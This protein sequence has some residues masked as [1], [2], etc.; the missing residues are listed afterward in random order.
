MIR[1]ASGKYRRS[2]FNILTHKEGDIPGALWEEFWL[3]AERSGQRGAL[4]LFLEPTA[5]VGSRNRGVKQV[6]IDPSLQWQLV[7]QVAIKKSPSCLRQQPKLK[8][9]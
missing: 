6:T 8:A 2:V 5:Q 7:R 3:G 4:V 9:Y 1:S